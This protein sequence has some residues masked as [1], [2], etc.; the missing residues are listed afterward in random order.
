MQH[1]ELFYHHMKKNVVAD[2]AVV[3]LDQPLMLDQLE[4]FSIYE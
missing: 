1:L 4:K 2:L 3:L